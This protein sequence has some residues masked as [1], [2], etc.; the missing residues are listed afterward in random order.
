VSAIFVQLQ[1]G[2]KLLI[3]WMVVSL[4]SQSQSS[5]NYR[6]LEAPWWA[7]LRRTQKACPQQRMNAPV[8]K[9]IFEIQ[10]IRLSLVK[11][12][13]VINAFLILIFLFFNYGF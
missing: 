9:T 1:W 12:Y 7:H 2:R 3:N 10:R 11:K 6:W 5:P 8:I 4:S 13:F